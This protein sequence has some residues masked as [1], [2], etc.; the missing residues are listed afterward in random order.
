MT[1]GKFETT[2]GNVVN[3]D[4]LSRKKKRSLRYGYVMTYMIDGE[5]EEVV[6]GKTGIGS[7]SPS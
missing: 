6:M 3:P 4:G 1:P 5:V 2:L 7:S